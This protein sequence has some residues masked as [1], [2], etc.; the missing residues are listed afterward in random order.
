MNG[1]A[2]HR[3]GDAELTEYRRRSLGI[4]FQFFNLLPTMTVL[5][6]VSLPLLLA[7]SRLKPAR[8]AA[9]AWLERA[10]L[11]NRWGHFPHQLS[12]GE[13]QRDGD[14]PGAGA[15]AGGAAGG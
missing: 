11:T 8:E 15:R 10:G 13:M 7:G 4:V 12:G 9:K 1:L 5:E 6:N 2:L 14:R 3:A